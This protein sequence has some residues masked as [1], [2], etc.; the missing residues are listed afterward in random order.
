MRPMRDF[1]YAKACRALFEFRRLQPVA[2][3]M[4]HFILIGAQKSGTSSVFSYL[5]QHPQILRPIFKEPYFFDRHYHRGLGWYGSNFPSQ[6]TIDRRNDRLGR[7]HLTFEATATYIFDEKVPNRIARDLKTRKFIL[8]LR[9]PVE[10]VIS[11]YWHA[12]R[13]GVESRSLAQVVDDDMRRY[14]SELAGVT[15]NSLSALALSRPSFLK[16][17]IY[18]EA[19]ARW[20]SVFSPQDLLVLQSESL[21]AEPAAAMTRIFDFLDIP[22]PGHIDYAPQNV[23]R[24]DDRDAQVR[25]LLREFYRPHNQRLN[26]ISRT[27]F[28]W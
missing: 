12:H 20:Q 16:R 19:V 2:R 22:Q 18:H 21:F 17:G 15:D 1:L 7:P 5:K 23:G 24:Y 26:S 27:Q 10:R 25:E 11:A 28:D 9:N 4:P 13:L 14:R 3:A 6:R 8:L